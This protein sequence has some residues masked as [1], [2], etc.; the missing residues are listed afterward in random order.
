LDDRLD[1]LLEHF[2]SPKS[3]FLPFIKDIESLLEMLLF[4][5]IDRHTMNMRTLSL[6]AQ[7]Y[8]I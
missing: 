7:I 2:F 3:L 5:A 8:L 6:A 4:C 1:K